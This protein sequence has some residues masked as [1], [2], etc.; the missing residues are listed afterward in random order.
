MGER[1]RVSRSSIPALVA[2]ALLLPS[3]A[4][5]EAIPVELRQAEDG[6][7]LLR[8]GEPY[9]IRGAGGTHSLQQ[10]AD[11]GA[12][13]IRTWGADDI[14]D[15]LDEAHSLGL[16]VTVGIWLGHERHGFDYNDT[17][18][19]AKQLEK[20]RQAVL[21]YKDHPAVLLWG[22]GNEMEGFESGDDPVIWA[23]V[24]DVAAMVKE[25]ENKTL[26]NFNC[27]DK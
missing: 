3:A 14:D 6:W 19:V 4:S 7:Q 18:Q 8:D 12:N 27:G 13:S 2:W 23:A 17:A 25:L 5:A 21:R 1:A 24:N 22:I 9:L 15:L 16:S 11:A 26:E 10:L 20:A